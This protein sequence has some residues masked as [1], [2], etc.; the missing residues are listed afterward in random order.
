MQKEIQQQLIQLTEQENIKIL[1]AVESG[2]RAWGCPSPDSDF[3]VRI[4]F[5]RPIEKYLSVEGSKE[6]INYFHGALLD[7]NGWDI[8]KTFKLLRKSNAT[9]FEWAQSP[10]IYQEVAGFRTTL[11]ALAKHYFQPRHS[12]NHYKGIAKNS[13]FTNKKAQRINLKKLFYVLRPL[14]AAKWII[15]KGS[16]PPMDIPTLLPMI[17][18]ANLVAKIQALLAIKAE[19]AEDYVHQVDQ[20]IFDFIEAAFALIET[21][22]LPEKEMPD[23]APLN[24]ALYKIIGLNQ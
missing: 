11:I 13:Y 19:A 4:I 22:Q 12:L 14:M 18:D 2:S 9:P 1:L 20:A 8:R 17:E 15:R 6:D 5:S 21:V 23:A 7:V 3:D 16:I 24:A 10:I